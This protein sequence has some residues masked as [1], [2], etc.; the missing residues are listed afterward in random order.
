M[1]LFDDDNELD[2][3]KNDIKR[4][5]KQNI[6]TNFNFKQYIVNLI[7]E[8]DSKKNKSNKSKNK[9]N[10]SKNKNNKTIN[11]LVNDM[12]NIV[13]GI[14]EIKWIDED[15]QKQIQSSCSKLGLDFDTVYEYLKQILNKKYCVINS[16]MYKELK[17]NLQ[18]L[19]SLIQGKELRKVLS[20]CFTVKRIICYERIGYILGNLLKDKYIYTN[21]KSDPSCEHVIPKKFYKKE[22]SMVTDMH[23]IFLA[24]SKINNIRDT[25][26]FDITDSVDDIQ[27]I[28]GSYSI[29]KT[30]SSCCYSN[31]HRLFYPEPQSRGR[32]SRACAYFFTVY[33]DALPFLYDVIDIDIMK[34]WC[35]K[36]KPAKN[37]YKRNYFVYQIQRNINPYIL[38]PKL[39]D[40]AFVDISSIYIKK[41]K[42]NKQIT[43]GLDVIQSEISKLNNK[44]TVYMDEIESVKNIHK[45]D[46][47][48]EISYKLIQLNKL[49]KMVDLQLQL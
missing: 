49:Q 19:C 32:I 36:Y 17:K 40:H 27:Y 18:L 11:K 24:P 44:L 34:S 25:M 8:R 12:Y 31:T 46:E 35:L 9:S 45:T 33:P 41:V 22:K 47:Y 26:K 43:M 5:I 2:I 48:I 14:G 39:I 7:Q 20:E 13:N 21:T 16:D 3:I 4:C 37:E 6:Y 28:N 30:K 23:Q 29:K 10:K 15:I 42:L 1:D 38:F